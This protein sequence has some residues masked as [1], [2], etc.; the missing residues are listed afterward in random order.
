MTRDLPDTVPLPQL[1]IVDDDSG[2][3]QV[4]AEILADMGD[5]YFAT[6]GEMAIALIRERRPDLVLLDAEMPGLHGFDV[7]KTVKA[8]PGFADLPILFVTAHT[9]IDHEIR[10]LDAGAVD[11]ISKPLSPPVVRARVKTHLALKQRTDQ[12]LRLA[13]V[14]GLTGVANRRSFDA[15]VEQEWRR[16]CRQGSFLSL[17]LV[18]VDYFKR[19]NDAYG[20]QAGDDCLRA[21]AMALAAAARRPGEMLARYGG[22]EFVAILPGCDRVRATLIAEQMRT[23]VAN[24]AISHC[25]SDVSPIVSISVGIGSLGAPATPMA[26]ARAGASE[27]LAAADRAMYRAKADGRNRAVA[28]TI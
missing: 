22:E 12:L 21:V 7:C 18:D 19:Y 27:L 4:L 17:L 20:H 14:D 8:D 28:A 16:A 9:D 15:A 6:S 24:L 11:F 5:V 2:T 26:S 1:L 23:L 25:Q 10:A 3:I 13:A